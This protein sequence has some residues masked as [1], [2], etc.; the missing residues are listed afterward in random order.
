MSAAPKDSDGPTPDTRT[1]RLAE[2]WEAANALAAAQ[3]PR[4][5]NGSTC[6][7]IASID[8]GSL[9]PLRTTSHKCTTKKRISDAGNIV[10]QAWDTETEG[11]IEV[12]SISLLR[13]GCPVGG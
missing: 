6:S 1:A 8:H 5:F 9:I 10:I 11:A 7:E 2:V 4:Q 12:S 13:H 3:L